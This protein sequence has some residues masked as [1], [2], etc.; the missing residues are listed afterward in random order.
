MTPLVLAKATIQRPSEPTKEIW[1][2][3][4]LPVLKVLSKELLSTSHK[5]T[6]LPCARARI[7]ASGE[8][9]AS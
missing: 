9:A 2:A 7:V 5:V 1:W 6:R 3:P 4:S 8:N